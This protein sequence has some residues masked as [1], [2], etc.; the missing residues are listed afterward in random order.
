MTT[1]LT[2]P[3]PCDDYYCRPLVAIS[4]ILSP[5]WLTIYFALENDINILTVWGPVTGA[6]VLCVPFFIGVVI[7]RSAP[8]GDGPMSLWAS[9][10][11]F[12]A[13]LEMDVV[14]R[15]QKSQPHQTYLDLFASIV[16]RYL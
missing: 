1:Q 2:V 3:I 6:V 16:D 5:V 15:W 8:S 14:H 9:V 4:T 10:S 7:L 13:L 11:C 12:F